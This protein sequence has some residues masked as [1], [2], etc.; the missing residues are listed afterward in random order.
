MPAFAA[1][2]IASKDRYHNQSQFLAVA[3]GYLDRGI[4]LSL[5]TVDW[6]VTL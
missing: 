6:C 4:P 1:G 3:R 2:F 5:L